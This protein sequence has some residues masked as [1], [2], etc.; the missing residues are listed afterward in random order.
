MSFHLLGE[1][2]RQKQDVRKS[3]SLEKHATKILGRFRERVE[4]NGN[5][6]RKLTSELHRL[7]G[8]VG[9]THHKGI[10]VQP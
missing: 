8:S 10:R 1:V 2:P 3:I 9:D 5:G 7:S 6:R 4:A